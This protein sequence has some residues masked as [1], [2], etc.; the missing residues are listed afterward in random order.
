MREWDVDLAFAAFAAITDE[1]AERVAETLTS[2]AGALS[3]RGDHLSVRATLM[4]GDPSEALRQTR[5]L[6]ATSA[7]ALA[8]ESVHIAPTVLPDVGLSAAS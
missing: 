3:Y 2:V 8:L 7:V 4:A 6:L 5:D 1:D